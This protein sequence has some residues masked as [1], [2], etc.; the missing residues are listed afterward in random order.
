MIVLLSG[1]FSI[2]PNWWCCSGNSVDSSGQRL[3]WQAATGMNCPAE[4]A[5]WIEEDVFHF[6]ASAA[7]RGAN[8][9]MIILTHQ[10]LR[11]LQPRFNE[12]L[13]DTR[14]SILAFKS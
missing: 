2:A 7:Y 14:I 10:N 1:A 12:R 4:T 6:P 11:G 3:K 9:D 13:V 5:T 8:Y